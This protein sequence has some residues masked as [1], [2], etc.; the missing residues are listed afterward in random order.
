MNEELSYQVMNWHRSNGGFCDTPGVY[1]HH[2]LRLL[3]E[4]V[5]LCIAAGAVESDIMESVHIEIGK[6]QEKSSGTLSGEVNLQ[7]MV[8]EVADVAIL[9]EVFTQHTEIS[10]DDAVHD[11]LQILQ[12][13]K[14]R[15][16]KTGV[17]WRVR[18]EEA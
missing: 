18:E 16:A 8:E 3:H 1:K 15:A 11:K 10:I 6:A 2:T 14:W 5:E 17:L 7:E 13:R 12:E 4:A 9:L